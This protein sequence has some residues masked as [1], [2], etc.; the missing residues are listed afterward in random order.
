MRPSDVR[1]ES[2]NTAYIRGTTGDQDRR[3]TTTAT[4]GTSNDDDN[5]TCNEGNNEDA[6]GLKQVSNMNYETMEPGVF[7]HWGT[8]ETVAPD[9]QF[10]V[11]YQNPNGIKVTDNDH[12]L[13]HMHQYLFE[14]NVDIAC[15]AETNLEWNHSW[16]RRKL[17]TTGRRRWKLFQ[18]TTSTSARVFANSYKPGGMMMFSAGPIQTRLV[19]EG[20]DPYKMGRWSFQTFRGK[21]NIRV[22]FITAYRV[23]RQSILTAGP[24]TSFFQQYHNIREGG[25]DNP[26][27]RK[28]ILQ[29]LRS[30]IATLRQDPE[31]EVFISLDA[32]ESL[33][34]RSQIQ[35]FFEETGMLSVHET[36]FG[37]NYYTEN[38]IPATYSRGLTKISFMAGTPQ[39]VSCVRGCFIEALD[40]GLHLD[41]RSMGVDFDTV[42]VSQG[43]I[44][45]ICPARERMLQSLSTRTA[46]NYRVEL[47]KRLQQQNVMTRVSNLLEATKSGQF[48]SRMHR[49]AEQI[50][51]T[52]SESMLGAEKA[53]CAHH[54][55]DAWSPQLIRTCLTLKFW[56]VVLSGIRN[57]RDV[58]P[59]LQPITSKV[60][61]LQ[62]S[63]RLIPQ[64]EAIEQYRLAL[65]KASHAKQRSETLREQFLVEQAKVKAIQGKQ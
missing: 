55:H 4:A 51:A 56:R 20:S 39:L 30:F 59:I 32:N 58:T 52:I 34:T 3:Y 65:K 26:N 49:E 21:E 57:K 25:D 10:R 61:D 35:D 6:N 22:T 19:K 46:A 27:P 33:G 1:Y 15:F 23:T 54:Y 37:D 9:H 36:Y 63:Q 28:R 50:D 42:A 38:P 44:A 41:H 60:K 5:H 24:A 12:S 18:A 13:K 16:V 43:E 40:T 8:P 48:S 53:A 62:V 2:N 17:D 47:R 14:Q 64:Q 45:S 31:H 7:I 11:W 29:D